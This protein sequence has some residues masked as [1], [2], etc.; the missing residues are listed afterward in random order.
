MCVNSR[1]GNNQRDTVRWGSGIL[2]GWV[3]VNENFSF[4]GKQDFVI[5]KFILKV[6]FIPFVTRL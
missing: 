1:K 5:A 6:L 4:T 3:F 2:R